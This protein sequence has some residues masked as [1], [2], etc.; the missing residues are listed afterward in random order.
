MTAHEEVKSESVAPGLFINEAQN[1]SQVHVNAELGSEEDW[2]YP[3]PTDFQ[4]SEHY[5]DDVAALKVCVIGAGL[6]GITAG[7]LLPAKVPGIEL[8]IIEKNADVVRPPFTLLR[9]IAGADR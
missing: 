5:I 4:I 6:A 7:V 1:P 8:T 2:V 3:W 9:H